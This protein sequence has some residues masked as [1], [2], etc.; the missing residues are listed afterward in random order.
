MDASGVF[1]VVHV[2]L[3]L[4]GEARRTAPLARGRLRF[5][6]FLFLRPLA[7]KQVLAEPDAELSRASWAV[8]EDGTP[9]VTAAARGKGQIVLFHVTG[10]FE[11]ARLSRL[12]SE[13][14]IGLRRVPTFAELGYPQVNMPGWAG[15]F[16]PAKTPQA[17]VDKLAAE[18]SR[19]V[20]LPD[21]KAKLLELGF[22]PVAWNAAK[23]QQFM[24]EQLAATRKL[25]DSG[26]VKL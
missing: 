7:A 9:L 12:V 15:A 6:R 3:F 14:A 24:T 2:V 4:F 25:V 1:D 8:L 17:V 10:E 13:C 18:M 20:M 19:I 23:T 22:E 5:G 11:C 21:V 16:V 26:R